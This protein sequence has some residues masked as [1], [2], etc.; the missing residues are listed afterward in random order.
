MSAL[1]IASLTIP[2]A[3]TTT[4]THQKEWVGSSSRTFSGTLRT[5]VRAEKRVWGVTTGLMLAADADSLV[6][7]VAL[8]A[9]VSCSGDVIDT[10]GGSVTC[11]VTV[12]DS[13]FEGVNGGDGKT[14][15]RILTMT[16]REV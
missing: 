13:S 1:V 12:G 8:G 11:E 16:I 10:A 7:A 5:T 6:A 4:V 9:H 3:P 15:M 14:F 2:V